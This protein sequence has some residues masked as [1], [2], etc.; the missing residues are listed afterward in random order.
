MGMAIPDSSPHKRPHQNR[1]TAGN[2]KEG[3]ANRGGALGGLRNRYGQ[4]C[5]PKSLGLERGCPGTASEPRPTQVPETLSGRPLALPVF[6]WEAALLLS[7]HQ[8]LNSLWFPP[9][10]AFPGTHG[11]EQAFLWT[12]PNTP[13]KQ[14]QID[15]FDIHQQGCFLWLAFLQLLSFSSFRNG[16]VITPPFQVS[17]FVPGSVARRSDLSRAFT[18]IWHFPAYSSVTWDSVKRDERKK[19]FHSGL[20]LATFAGAHV[21]A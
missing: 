2:G 14:K 12:R 7:K 6:L 10:F 8:G 5:K 18:S 16:W 11:T 1:H 19:S 4:A 9:T 17:S 3:A 13:P 15:W 20:K 21:A